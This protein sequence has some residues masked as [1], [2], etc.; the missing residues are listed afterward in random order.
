VPPF[1]A[2]VQ[3]GPIVKVSLSVG[4]AIAEQIRAAGG[5]LPAPVSG[6]ALIDTGASATCIDDAAAQTLRLPVIDVVTMTSA[7]HAATRCNVYPVQIEAIGFP[8]NINTP[9]ALGAEL[10]A[11][12]LV[13][14]IGRDV[15]RHCLLVYNGLTGS[16]S[17]SI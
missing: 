9:R 2:L 10:Q 4:Q 11:Q 3:R 14:L 17:L 6:L 1:A 5:E 13:M 15:L 12:G 7:S 8:M 16:F